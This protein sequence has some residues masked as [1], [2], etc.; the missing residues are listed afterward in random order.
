MTPPCT[1]LRIAVPVP[2]HRFYDYLLPP[3]A[4]SNQL[5]LGIRIKVPFGKR[6]VIGI[7]VEISTTSDVPHS[8]LKPATEIIDTQPLFS[9]SVLQLLRWASD[10]YHYPLGEVFAT[11]IPKT[12]RLG[13][14][15]SN[16]KKI[17]QPLLL[18]RPKGLSHLIKRNNKQSMQYKQPCK[19]SVS[20]Y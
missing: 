1:I 10:Y 16:R 18:N 11:A 9:P 17:M 20:F 4:V 7:L 13:K 8:K 2:L 6:E 5:L 12:L 15:P 14:S 3:D 19:N